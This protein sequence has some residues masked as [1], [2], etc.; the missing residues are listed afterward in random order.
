MDHRL[1]KIHEMRIHQRHFVK[2][3]TLTYLAPFCLHR[4][5]RCPRLFFSSINRRCAGAPFS[6]FLFL[7][8]F[9]LDLS[10]AWFN[11]SL[12]FFILFSHQREQDIRIYSSVTIRTCHVLHCTLDI[13]IM[14]SIFDIF[15]CFSINFLRGLFCVIY[16]CSRSDF[17]IKIIE[18]CIFV[19]TLKLEYFW[20]VICS[21]NAHILM[22]IFISNYFFLSEHRICLIIR[23]VEDK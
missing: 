11:V 20:F 6:R 19:R 8:S 21:S 1:Y 4:F 14:S 7:S 5:S 9:F 10:P 17:W 2:I 22:N 13:G 16:Q 12:F 18:T 23:K 15:R 3:R